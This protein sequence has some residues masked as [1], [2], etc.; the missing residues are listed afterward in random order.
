MLV[1][2]LGA[3]K[4]AP[5]QPPAAS[6]DAIAPPVCDAGKT[7]GGG[8]GGA[9]MHD[10]HAVGT[11]RPEGGGKTEKAERPVM[12]ATPTAKRP[13]DRQVFDNACRSLKQHF[14]LRG[15]LAGEHDVEMSGKM[16]DPGLVPDHV[17]DPDKRLH[18]KKPAAC[19]AAGGKKIRIAFHVAKPRSDPSV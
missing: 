8:V 14:R 11:R 1:T 18:D 5:I 2:R 4:N 7:R 19:A 9:V 13:F 15:R 6:P 3:E 16:I 17:S 10:K 12:T